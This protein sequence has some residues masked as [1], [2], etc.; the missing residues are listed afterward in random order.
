MRKTLFRAAIVACAAVSAAVAIQL[1][2]A[3]AAPPESTGAG[4]AS[5]EGKT[6]DLR[7][8]W[9]DAQ[10]CVVQADARTECFRTDQEANAA[11]GYDRTKDPAVLSGVEPLAAFDCADGWLCLY[12]DI[13]GEGR[14]LIFND[15]FWHNLDDWGFARKTSSWRNRQ[16]SVFCADKGQLGDGAGGVL[17][18]ESCARASQMGSWNDRAIHVHG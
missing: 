4:L 15:E 17:T 2:S 6:V 13:N 10:S 8:G 12:E 7:Q 5:F 11:V 3:T 9:G 1:P 18:L 16:S 14:R